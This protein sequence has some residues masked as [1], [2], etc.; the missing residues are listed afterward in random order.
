[1]ENV[2]QARDEAEALT[3]APELDVEPR[4]RAQL[5]S[6]GEV[7]HLA[8]LHGQHRGRPV[9]RAERTRRHADA[10][11]QGG[12]LERERDRPGND[13]ATA[14]GDLEPS[15]ALDRADAAR[16]ESDARSQL[17]GRAG[18]GLKPYTRGSCGDRE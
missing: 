5:S 14:A 10:A 7:P 13:D 4:D 12:A 6:P 18:T 15:P 16:E 11:D 17:D 3:P 1:G 9:R 2:A 8:C